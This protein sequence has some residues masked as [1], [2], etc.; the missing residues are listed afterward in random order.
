[1]ST[2]RPRR[3]VRQLPADAAWLTTEEVANLTGIPANTLKY[4]RTME[5]KGPPFRRV[6][7]R[8]VRYHLAAVEA[9]LAQQPGGGQVA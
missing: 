3:P 2:R 6:N 4:W 7:H 1:M 8:L 5:G 9:W